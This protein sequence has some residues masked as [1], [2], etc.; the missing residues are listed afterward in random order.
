MDDF[1]VIKVSK[2]GRLD[3]SGWMRVEDRIFSPVLVYGA[4]MLASNLPPEVDLL[5]PATVEA[6]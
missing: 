2:A 6:W 4:T 1:E 3:L 5:T